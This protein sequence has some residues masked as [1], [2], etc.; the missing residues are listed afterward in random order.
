MRIFY[1]VALWW[2]M[3][4]SSCLAAELPASSGTFALHKFAKAIGKET[5]SIAQSGDT[6][7]LSSHFEFTD[8]GTKVPLETTFVARTGNLVP[9]SYLAKGK[10]SRFAHMDDAVTVEGARLSILRS[11]GKETV[12]ADEPWFIADGYSPVVMQEQMMEASAVVPSNVPGC[13]WAVPSE[14]AAA[15]CRSLSPER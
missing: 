13:S 3:L 4:A 1:I 6:Y 9:V 11:N 14:P 12:T 10:A 8:R 7:T 2:A 5:Y 15:L